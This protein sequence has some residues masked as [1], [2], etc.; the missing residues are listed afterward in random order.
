M[1]LTRLEQQY[2]ADRRAGKVLNPCPGHD[3]TTPWGIKGDAWGIGHH[4][5]EDH[6]A[7]VGTPV[8]AVTWGHVIG[9]GWSA[10]GWGADYGNMVIIET[11]TGK[12]DYAYCHLHDMVVRVGQAVVPGMVLAHVGYTGHVLPVGPAGAHLHFEARPHGG[13]YGSDIDPIRVKKKG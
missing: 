8:V 1:S 6:A 7:P 3:V 5:G 9:V 12:Y 11:A 13:R 2:I 10:L 4:T